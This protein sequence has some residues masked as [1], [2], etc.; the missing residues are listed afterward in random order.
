[1]KKLDEISAFITTSKHQIELQL[2]QLEE[3]WQSS[4]SEVFENDKWGKVKLMDIVD[5]V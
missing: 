3:L 5:V 1:V 2:K 4:L